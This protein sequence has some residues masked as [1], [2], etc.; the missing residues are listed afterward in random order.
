[1]A[2][3]VQAW[4]PG[5]ESTQDMCSAVCMQMKLFTTKFVEALRRVQVFLVV[6]RLAVNSVGILAWLVITTSTGDESVQAQTSPAPS[7]HPHPSSHSPTTARQPTPESTSSSPEV[8]TSVAM[9]T[10]VTSGGV[11]S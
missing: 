5:A 6:G 10:S 3:A 8:A 7:P 9:T 11:Y 1:M 4:G 2:L